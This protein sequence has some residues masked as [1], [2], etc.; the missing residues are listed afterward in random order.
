MHYETLK[1]NLDRLF[2][3]NR[4]ARRLFYQLLDLLLLRSWHLHR[5]V[6]LW[7]RDHAGQPAHILDAGTGFGQNAYWLSRRSPKW[8]VL[9]V[10]K[11]KDRVCACN[12]FF[13]EAGVDN[14][15]CRTQDLTR[16]ETPRAFELVLS[17][18][19]L[20]Y[21][22]EDVQTLTNL[23]DALK[24]GGMLLICS[25]THRAGG[26]ALD[27]QDLRE[28][29]QRG[30][31]Q[32]IRTGYD[33]QELRAKLR[34]AGFKKIAMRYIYGPAGRLSWLLSM[35]W[36]GQWLS[37]SSAVVALLP[38]YYLLVYP[39]C[40]VLN[41]LD[42][43]RNHRRGMGLLVNAWKEE[44]PATRPDPIP[45]DELTPVEAPRP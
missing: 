40:F 19:V 27:G 23:Y 14:V 29:A 31:A 2:G 42:M 12:Q 36:P 24:P 1:S 22:E 4:L 16:L 34:A 7:A 20:T 9:A 32:R 37:R 35:R 30:N 26:I 6:K 18:D 15:F 44:A 33:K 5:E 21:V 3:K 17:V 41:W 38:L 13:H 10:D 28:E 8:S 39:V 25:P 11:R 45:A 43:R